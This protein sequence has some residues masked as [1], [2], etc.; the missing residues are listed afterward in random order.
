MMISPKLQTQENV[1]RLR[2]ARIGVAIISAGLCGFLIV[3][4]VLGLRD[5]WSAE[6]DLKAGRSRIFQLA[7]TLSN[8]KREQRNLSP[9]GSTGVDSFA[10]SF[11]SWAREQGVSIQSLVPEGAPST[12][13]IEFEDADLGDWDAAKIRVKGDADFDKFVGLLRKF[14]DPE[15][16]V[17]LESFGLQSGGGSGT[18][19]FELL[20]TV[21]EKKGTAS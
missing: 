15:M 13:K 11:A 14:R 16:P 3:N 6:A 19:S 7:S 18:I 12:S 2:Y 5:I 4:T 8:M 20:L 21:Y 1:N 9:M 10:V 17:Q